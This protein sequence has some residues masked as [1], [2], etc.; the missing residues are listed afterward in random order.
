[1]EVSW[2]SKL[3]DSLVEPPHLPGQLASC[4]QALRYFAWIKSLLTHSKLVC[5]L[6]LLSCVFFVLRLLSL[7]K[8]AI[9][10]GITES[11]VVPYVFCYID[12]QGLKSS[13]KV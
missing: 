12:K 9:T 5:F 8:W 4:N 10:F 2:P 6:F 3:A 13:K 1:M 11:G 7:I